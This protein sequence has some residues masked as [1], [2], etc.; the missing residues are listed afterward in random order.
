ME[1]SR[2][3]QLLRRV[4]S[5]LRWASLGFRFYGLV[6][7]LASAHAVLLLCS[8]LLALTPDWFGPLSVL[9]V[10]LGA[11]LVALALTRRAPLLATARLVDERAQ[12]DDLFLTARLLDTSCG[13]YQELVRTQAIE[14]SQRLSPRAIV[15]FGWR[16]RAFRIIV[17][18]A[19]LTV[20]TVATPQLDPFGKQD[21]RLRVAERK[22]W[23]A[24]SRKAAALRADALRRKQTAEAR[25]SEQVQK[26]VERLLQALNEARPEAKQLNLKRLSDNQQALGQLWRKMAVGKLQG[27]FAQ[28]SSGQ[29]FGGG[30]ATQ[31]SKWRRQLQKGNLTPLRDELRELSELAEQLEALPASSP[32][33]PERKSELIR[34]L[35]RLSAFLGE[36]LTSDALSQ[37]LRRAQQQLGL[38]GAGD[39]SR[40]ALRALQESLAL[41]GLEMD[42]L[43]QNLKDLETLE[44]AMKAA[45]LAKMLNALEALDGTACDGCQDVQDYAELYEQLMAQQAEGMGGGM[46]GP[47]TGQG[48]VAPEDD[49]QTTDF[50]PEKATSALTA[51]KML[52]QWKTREVSRPGQARSDYGEQVKDVRQGVSEA[53]VKEQ[54]PPGYHD[55]IRKYFGKLGASHRPDSSQ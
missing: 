26:E 8:R 15:P 54:V 6:L 1:R 5:R 39:L 10:P 12:T 30:D 16:R 46:R 48:N 3:E 43:G 14:L 20:A 24:E 52:L 11:L 22:Q 28:M 7:I 17:V 55:G 50:Q 25:Q 47:G 27:A 45:Q 19:C 23:L 31:R 18:M 4:Q 36:N 2:V 53:I 49:S 9:A 34:R 33:R 13:T 35:K 21:E 44:Q 42:A 37:A 41:A 32:S 38:A 29:Q 51:G 40:D